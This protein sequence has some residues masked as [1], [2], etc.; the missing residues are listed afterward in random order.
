[1][2]LNQIRAIESNKKK[3]HHEEISAL[4]KATMKEA[5]MNGFHRVYHPKDDEGESLPPESQKVQF[6]YKEVI[7]QQNGRLAELFDATATRDWTNCEANA[8]VVVE[9][10]VFLEGAP[11]HYL[12]YLE[13]QLD[14]QRTFVSKMVELDPG[15]N[16]AWDENSGQFKSDVVAQTKKA[17]KKRAIVM[18]DATVEHPAQ[19][20]L[21]DDEVIVG[22]WKKTKFSG[23]IPGP[24][25]KRI[26]ARI[27]TLTDAVKFAREKANSTEALPMKVGKKVLD[28]LF[29]EVA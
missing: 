14:D 5:L 13:K 9:G 27:Q 18:Y 22:T 17:K 29:V 23:A 16:W 10:E 15:E 8:D 3:H 2:K 6:R 4:H 11:V 19:T 21:I 1:M 25:K 26:L 12:L 28:Y 24:E 20:Q 7:E